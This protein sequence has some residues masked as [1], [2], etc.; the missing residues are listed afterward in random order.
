[1][2]VCAVLTTTITQSMVADIILRCT[3]I[4]WRCTALLMS[5][6]MSAP[7]NT[8]EPMLWYYSVRPIHMPLI[9]LVLVL[10]F[11]VEAT[12]LETSLT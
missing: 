4:L 12:V 3:L 8:C 7:C 9:V 10:V 5:F 11:K 1:M 2:L 6:L